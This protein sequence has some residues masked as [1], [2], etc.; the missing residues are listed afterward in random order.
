MKYFIVIVLNLNN[1]TNYFKIY[2]S[3]NGVKNS[4][5]FDLYDI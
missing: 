1:F 3:N 2:V 5:F 4:Q